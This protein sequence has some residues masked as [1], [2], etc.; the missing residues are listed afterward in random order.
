ML[1]ALLLA[2]TS[3][4][5]LMPPLDYLPAGNRN[6]AFGI[7]LPPPGTSVAELRRVG[8]KLQERMVTRTAP[9][10]KLQPALRRSFF[11]G[12]TEQVFCGIVAEDPSQIKA[13]KDWVSSYHRS[14]P[15]FMGFTVQPSIF[16]RIEGGR[17]VTI[18]FLGRDLKQLTRIAR[19]AFAAIRQAVPGAQVRP[20][21]S[22]DD[23]ALELRAYPRR[24]QVARLSMGT[25]ELGQAIDAMVDGAIIGEAG[26]E[27]EPQLDVVLRAQRQSGETIDDAEALRSSPIVTP[28]GHVVPLGT[29]TDIKRELGPTKIRRSERQRAITLQVAPPDEIAVESAVERIETEVLGKM[30]QSG[31]LPGDVETSITGTAGD[32][33]QAIADY[34][35][36]LLL[37]LLISYLL[38]SA[39]FEDFLAPLVILITVPLATM[40]GLLAL[41][42][43]DAV[44]VRQPLDLLT[45]VGFLILL[46]VIVNNAILVVDGAI[47]RLREGDNLVD[48]ISAASQ[49]RV[50]PILMTT[51]TSLAGLLP[52]VISQ[53]SGAELYRGVATVVLGGLAF[54]TV[55]TLV[56]VPALFS[57]VWQLRNRGQA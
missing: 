38:M 26:L 46:G 16:G 29:L 14:I 6:I 10:S 17:A 21:P 5:L 12:L 36:I 41:R 40:G 8:E 22:L 48:A 50:R 32:L 9:D 30:R 4:Y 25:A 18:D 34:K 1:G 45:A 43:V 7:L 23:G 49:S 24:N 51:G 13:L 54:G 28:S 20:L 44:Y 33:F 27:G 35:F 31:A 2:G 56:V 15:G 37:A 57:L 3:V 47:D 55:L 19:Q 39:L 42:L 11:V 53:G 52:M